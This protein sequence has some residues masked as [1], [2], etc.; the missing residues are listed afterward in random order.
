[1]RHEVIYTLSGSEAQNVVRASLISV[2]N[3]LNA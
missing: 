3:Q 1:M 2:T